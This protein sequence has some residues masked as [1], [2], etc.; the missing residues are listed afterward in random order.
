MT[1]L[2]SMLGVRGKSKGSVASWN[3]PQRPY[4]T[5]DDLDGDLVEKEIEAEVQKMLEPFSRPQSQSGV[6]NQEILHVCRTFTVQ[7]ILRHRRLCFIQSM[8]RQPEEHAQA[9][10]ALVGS[11]EYDVGAMLDAES[12]PTRYAPAW[13]HLIHSDLQAFMGEEI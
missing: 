4:E 11:S 3:P 5:R 10:A 7:S 1:R 6:T 12:K 9:W 2:R 13:L 8:A